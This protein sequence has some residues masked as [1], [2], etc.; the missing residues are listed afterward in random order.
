MT[1]ESARALRAQL[2]DEFPGQGRGEDVVDI[3]VFPCEPAEYAQCAGV[4]A[5]PGQVEIVTH[6]DSL[7]PP[8]HDMVRQRRH[9]DDA[10][11]DA[12]ERYR[13]SRDTWCR[14]HLRRRL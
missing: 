2:L 7:D 1:V 6:V 12:L 5:S 8:P 9:W 11:H 3:R 13:R 14:H 4:D 10:V